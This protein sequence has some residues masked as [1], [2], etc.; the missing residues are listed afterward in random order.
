[1]DLA[2]ARDARVEY[3][4]AHNEV[5]A[6]PN[7]DIEKERVP[8]EPADVLREEFEGLAGLVRY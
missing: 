3:V 4:V 2:A 1:M 6:T 5:A 8:D 7:E